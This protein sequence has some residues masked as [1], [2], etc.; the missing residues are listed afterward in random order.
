MSSI[1]FDNFR[2]F[3]KFPTI[4]LGDVT[5]LVGGNNS[6]KSTLV[7][8]FLLCVDNLRLMR[9]ND[10][11]RNLFKFTKPI[12]RFDANEFHD[13]KVKTFSRAIHNKVVDSFDLNTLKDFKGLPTT[14]T[15]RFSLG[16]FVFKFV[17]TGDRDKDLTTGEVNEISI[18]DEEAHIRFWANYDKHRM[19]Y[20]VLNADGQEQFGLLSQLW[21][22]YK[23]AKVALDKANDEGDLENITNLTTKLDKIVMQINSMSDRDDENQELTEEEILNIAEKFL[24]KNNPVKADYVLP[25]GILFD[26]VGENV[27]LNVI[28]NIINFA[29][30]GINKPE[31]KKGQD[32]GE[33]MADLD[34]YDHLL[35]FQDA[36]KLDLDIIMKSRRDLEML[37]YNLGV[38][39]ISAHSAN[40]NTL[41]NT[42]D[43]NDYIAQTVHEFYRERINAGESEHVFVR[44][45]MQSFG[46]GVDFTINSISGEAYQV[47]IK[48]EDGTSV[49][50]ADKGMGAIQ[51]MILLLRL[52]TIIRRNKNASIPTTIVIEE[53]EQNLHPKMQ[54]K[55]AELFEEMATRNNCTFII[56]T[57]SEYIVRKAQVLV[58]EA[59]YIDDSDLEEHNP[60][61]IY[62]LP[63]DGSDRY[64]MVFRTDGCFENDFGEGFFDEAENLALKIL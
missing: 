11:G 19:A 4:D 44:N 31:K 40:Q 18:E 15:F 41:Y 2:K 57:H 42:A 27:V 61:K 1:G 36:I 28:S 63:E 46:I 38:E 26:E 16:Q 53:P 8:A 54:S 25:L 17:V 35:S 62:Y 30:T 58:R 5:I 50:L 7:K 34:T 37:I 43:R 10:G 60:F 47:I 32:P 64:E 6:G 55:L 49:P 33:Y 59:N 51:M 14:I 21:H 23:D 12:F 56:E 29:T 13:V 24:K 52:A 48:D 20:E 3:A 39:Y 22:E 45:W 9:M